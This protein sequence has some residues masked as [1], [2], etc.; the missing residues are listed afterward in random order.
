MTFTDLREKRDHTQRAENERVANS[1][2]AALRGGYSEAFDVLPV[3]G[4]LPLAVRVRITRGLRPAKDFSLDPILTTTYGRGEGKLFAYQ[5]RFDWEG[6]GGMGTIRYPVRKDGTVDGERL[7]NDLHQ[8]AERETRREE[9]AA[10]KGRR[11]DETRAAFEA[12]EKLARKLSG[13]SGS[14]VFIQV[15]HDG[16]AEGR[17]VKLKISGHVS[18][19]RAMAL[20]NA[21]QLS[22]EDETAT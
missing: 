17:P 12:V 5:V 15:E 13:A 21:V 20:L 7:K 19:A 10:L 4:G 1:V 3:D 18:A 2:R 6:R 9:A 22:H 11:I 8:W 14:G 16:S